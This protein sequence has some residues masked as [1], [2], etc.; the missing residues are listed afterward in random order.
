MLSLVLSTFTSADLHAQITYETDTVDV[1][2]IVFND[3]VPFIQEIGEVDTTGLLISSMYTFRRGMAFNPNDIPLTAP[4]K[5]GIPFFNIKEGG[6]TYSVKEGRKYIIYGINFMDNPDFV[7]EINGYVLNHETK[8]EELDVV[9]PHSFQNLN[10]GVSTHADIPENKKLDFF[11]VY[12]Y[13]HPEKCPK[14]KWRI[15]LSFLDGELYKM[16]ADKY[17]YYCT[18]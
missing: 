14:P 15:Q 9:F 10:M 12:G 1:K 18:E 17:S 6:F 3:T 5:T 8:L 7:L 4:V 13:E 2:K 11:W 16:I